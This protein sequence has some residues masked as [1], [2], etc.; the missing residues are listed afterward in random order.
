MLKHYI[1][2]TI[3]SMF[4]IGSVVIG[5]FIGGSPSYING[6]KM[7]QLK[8]AN[9]ESLK[10]AIETYLDLE[11]KLPNT[12]EELQSNESVRS[13]FPDLITKQKDIDYNKIS[14]SSYTLCTTFTEDSRISSPYYI[15]EEFKHPA[16]Y[17]CFEFNS[18]NKYTNKQTPY[19]IPVNRI[20]RGF[21]PTH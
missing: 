9:T 10:Y 5:Y 6:V 18:R 20:D 12:P 2:L 8:V 7:D 15:S 13:K 11:G 17:Y 14:D 16:G 19:P 21:T 4:M 3:I 1:T